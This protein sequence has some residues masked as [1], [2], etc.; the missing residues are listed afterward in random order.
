MIP[1]AFV[2]MDA[3]PLTPN[4]KL[5]RSALAPPDWRHLSRA[6]P[7]ARPRTPLE[8][9]LRD[10]WCDVL[11]LEEVGI[12]E[13]FFEIGGRSRLGA[14]LFARI[15]TELGPRLPLATLF[16]APTIEGLARTVE[17]YAGD[18]SFGRWSPLVPIRPTGST[19]PLFC[20]HPVGGNVLAYKDL[21]RR[22]GPEVPC[23]GVQAVG[24]DGVTPPLHSVEE[25][26]ER[27]LHEIRSVQ[28]RG[29]YCLCGFSFGGLVAFEIALRLRAAGEEIGVLALLDTDFPD[30]VWPKQFDG[31]LEWRLVRERVYPIVQRSRRHLR[32]LGRL[33]IRGYLRLLGP[34]GS[35]ATGASP[36]NGAPPRGADAIA[37]VAER[38]RKANTRAALRYAPRRYDG[39]V[40]YFRA[41]HAMLERDRRSDWSRLASRL[42][43]IDVP[44]LHSDLRRE[45]LVEIV[46]RELAAR[47][48][49]GRRATRVA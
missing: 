9:R 33:G 44:G 39:I 42:D 49:A 22:L 10:L 38:V 43:V 20:I 2:M 11:G 29:P 31:A 30:L 7:E 3:L 25:M 8:R 40:T 23:Y 6:A 5:D 28:T 47:L 37:Q 41:Q 36:L 26:A 46:A 48:R 27:Y 13:N 17:R 1:S 21:A 14:Q 4:G 35:S 45:P 18:P 34:R 12:D 32:S 15:E 19:A 16:E 24:L